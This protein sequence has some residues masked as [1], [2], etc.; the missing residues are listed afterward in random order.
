MNDS[1]LKVSAFP[2]CMLIGCPSSP[3]FLAQSRS[4]CCT[5]YLHPAPVAVDAIMKFCKLVPCTA[6]SVPLVRMKLRVVQVCWQT[7]ACLLALFR[8]GILTSLL[9]RWPSPNNQT[10]YIIHIV[11]DAVQNEDKAAAWLFTQEQPMCLA[12]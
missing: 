2:L 3:C 9:N 12:W 7:L 8:A 10:V 5:L 1:R 4:C 6:P 11:I